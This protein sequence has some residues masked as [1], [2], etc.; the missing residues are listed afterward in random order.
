M[1]V[2]GVTMIMNEIIVLSMRA[3]NKVAST[4][5]QNCLSRDLLATWDTCDIP[6]HIRSDDKT[7]KQYFGATVELVS[8]LYHLWQSFLSLDAYLDFQVPLRH[9]TIDC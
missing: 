1:I 5:D 3:P 2:L 7:R 6:S 4:R 8:C 9:A